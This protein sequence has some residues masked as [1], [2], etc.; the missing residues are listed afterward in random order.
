MSLK[1]S[2][3]RYVVFIVAGIGALL[4][5]VG[6]L[7]RVVEKIRSG[8]GLDYYFTGFGVRFNYIGVLVLFVCIPTALLLGWVL[9]YW[10]SRDERDFI[11]RFGKE[12]E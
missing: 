3:A 9:N 1:K 5:L 6:F 10:L 12:I 2:S 7:L 4:A 11:K 8:H